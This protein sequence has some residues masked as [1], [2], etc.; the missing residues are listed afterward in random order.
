MPYNIH[1]LNKDSESIGIL[2]TNVSFDKGQQIMLETKEIKNVYALCMIRPSAN[3]KGF[4]VA[5]KRYL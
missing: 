1:K 3:G 4:I 2:K 5:D